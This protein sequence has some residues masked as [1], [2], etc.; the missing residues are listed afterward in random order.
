VATRCPGQTAER[1]SWSPT[2]RCNAI[3]KYMSS[4][5]PPHL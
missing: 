4:K 5:Y 1:A 2:V 3:T